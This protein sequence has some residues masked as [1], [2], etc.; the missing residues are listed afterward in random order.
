MMFARGFVEDFC[1]DEVVVRRL[2]ADGVSEGDA[3]GG[4]GEESSRE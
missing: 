2:E 1:D 4:R 3:D